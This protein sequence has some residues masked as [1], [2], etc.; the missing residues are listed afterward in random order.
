ETG[1]QAVLGPRL[2]TQQYEA[3]GIPKIV[4]YWAARVAS[5]EDFL[6]DDE[7]DEIRWMPIAHAR[8][9]LTYEHDADL[10]EQSATLPPTFPLIVLRHAQA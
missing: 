5:E 6:P 1:V 8:Q 3:L 10:V 7:I 9:L 4:D 2:P